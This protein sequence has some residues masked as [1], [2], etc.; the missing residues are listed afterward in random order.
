MQWNIN[1]NIEFRPDEKKL[2]SVNNPEINVTLT[3]PASRCLLLLLEASPD[4][5][6]QQDFFKKVWEEEG[7]LVPTNTLYQNISI[8][9]RGLRA[10]GETDRRLISTIPRKGFQID[11]SVKIAK[12]SDAEAKQSAAEVETGHIEK[13]TLF[14][15]S[16]APPVAFP[17]LTE[18][19]KAPAKDQAYHRG[20]CLPLLVIFIAFT[21]GAFA[22][23]FLWHIDDTPA[24]FNN[25]TLAESDNGCY[26]YVKDDSHDNKSNYLR[27]KTL[28]KNS[29]LNCKSYPWIYMPTSKTFPT[30]AAII[31]RHKY[32]IASAPGC[33]TLYFRGA[34]SD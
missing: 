8:V 28:I 30:L 3:T 23:W 27:Y 19:F 29:G 6:L 21:T 10:V 15:E 4:I 7:M 16:G 2:I 17:A 22:T 5:V 20:W 11:S 32:T 14:L 33:I 1:D 25:Y 24:F 31:C 18:V 34:N 12:K 26:F 13:E 9:R